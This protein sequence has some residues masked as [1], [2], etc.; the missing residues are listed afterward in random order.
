[1]LWDKDALQIVRNPWNWRIISSVLPVEVRPLES[2]VLSPELEVMVRNCERFHHPYRQLAI[3]LNGDGYWCLNGQVFPIS[4][5]VVLLVEPGEAHDY[6]ISHPDRPF[7]ILRIDLSSRCLYVLPHVS[8][9]QDL[10][11]AAIKND[12]LTDSDAGVLFEQCWPQR[13]MIGHIPTDIIRVRLISAL[14][15]VLCAIIEH[16]LGGPCKD[17]KA[18]QRD[19]VQEVRE[20]IAEDPGQGANLDEVARLAGYSRAYFARIFKQYSSQSLHEYLDA[21]RLTK[22]KEMENEGRSHKEIS[23]LLG[24]SSPSVFSSWLKRQRT[25]RFAV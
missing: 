16:D 19:V 18:F 3:V 17:R 5:G 24:F 25:R 9:T 4:P 8:V 6:F 11:Y 21:C 12:I 10:Q 7:L 20:R 15:I 23:A 1:M 13:R 14:F 2:T 22:T